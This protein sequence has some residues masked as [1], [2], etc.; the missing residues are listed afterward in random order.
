[1]TSRLSY[2]LAWLPYHLAC[3]WCTWLPS[4]WWS[5]RRS[6]AASHR[7]WWTASTSWHPTPPTTRLRCHIRAPPRPRRHTGHAATRFQTMADLKR[8]AARGNT[9]LRPLRW[10]WCTKSCLWIPHHWVHNYAHSWAEISRAQGSNLHDNRHGAE[11]FGALFSA[12]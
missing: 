4:G 6:T 10:R 12:R 5:R 1:V 9:G 2:H 3:W 11:Q 7:S 8:A